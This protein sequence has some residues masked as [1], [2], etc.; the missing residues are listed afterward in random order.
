M[1]VR[2][3][4]TQEAGTREESESRRPTLENFGAGQR[5]D[6]V[7]PADQLPLESRILE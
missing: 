7:S 6:S 2:R 3:G 1:R 5:A 4:Y